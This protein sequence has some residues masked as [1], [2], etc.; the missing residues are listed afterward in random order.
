MESERPNQRVGNYLFIVALSS[1]GKPRKSQ[2]TVPSPVPSRD[3]WKFV[4][5]LMMIFASP[6]AQTT[7][8]VLFGGIPSFYSDARAAAQGRC[9]CFSMDRCLACSTNNLFFQSATNTKQ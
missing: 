5:I 4:V 7:L 2:G 1:M 3:Y 9:L 8:R 6:S